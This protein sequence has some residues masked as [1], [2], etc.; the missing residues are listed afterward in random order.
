MLSAIRSLIADL[1][2]AIDLLRKGQALTS[3]D[4]ETLEH[5]IDDVESAIQ[6][7]GNNASN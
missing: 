4:L 7:D 1:R 5:D 3:G 2:F 6:E